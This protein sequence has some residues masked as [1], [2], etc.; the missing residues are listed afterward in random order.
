M[1]Q[2]MMI[3]SHAKQITILSQVVLNRAEVHARV[4][5]MAMILQK[6][7]KHEPVSAMVAQQGLITTAKHVI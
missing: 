6:H 1:D 4:S 2:L 5:T 3:A 7:V